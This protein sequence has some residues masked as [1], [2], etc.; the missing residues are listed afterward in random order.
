MKL[1]K[2]PSRVG[3]KPRG[4]VNVRFNAKRGTYRLRLTSVHEDQAETI[5]EALRKSRAEANTEYD[6]VAL[7]LICLNYLATCPPQPRKAEIER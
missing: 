6:V 7:E 5:F 1:K 2:H 4:R 3:L